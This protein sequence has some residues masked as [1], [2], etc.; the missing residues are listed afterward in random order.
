MAKVGRPRTIETPEE[1]ERLADSYFNSLGKDDKATFTGL[2]LHMGFESRQSFYAYKKRPEFSYV[3]RK[4]H[5][6]VEQ[7]YEEKL[8]SPHV[9][10]AVF[11][12]KNMGWSDRQELNVGGTGEPL[13]H[14]ITVTRRIVDPNGDDVSP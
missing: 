3:A 13:E 9:A 7:R 4:A 8:H 1:F 5:L 2:C 12:L 14:S 11:V 10:G 6:K